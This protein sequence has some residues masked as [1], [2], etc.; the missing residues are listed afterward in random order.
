ML[1]AGFQP[2]I[3]D[4]LTMARGNE[5][6]GYTHVRLKTTVREQ[7]LQ[8]QQCMSSVHEVGAKR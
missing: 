5:F 6:R 2:C 7:V 3:D 1:E 4:G 8:K